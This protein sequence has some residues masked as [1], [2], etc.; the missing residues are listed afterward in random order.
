MLTTKEKG[1]TSQFRASKQFLC[2]ALIPNACDRNVIS[3]NNLIF[4][5]V[6]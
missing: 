5:L 1:Q 3:N 2:V 6:T 4:K